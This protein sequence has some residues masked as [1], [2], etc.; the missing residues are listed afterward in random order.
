M[1]A[2]LGTA[3]A[4][5]GHAQTYRARRFESTIDLHW[6]RHELG[7]RCASRRGQPLPSGHRP[8]YEPAVLNVQLGRPNEILKRQRNWFSVGSDS[9]CCARRKPTRREQQAKNTDFEKMFGT[10]LCFHEQTRCRKPNPNGPIANSESSFL[11]REFPH[12]NR[13]T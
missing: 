6:N 13:N 9:A 10:L 12:K 8:K 3:L 5:I 7:H 11:W 4:L 2:P 1:T